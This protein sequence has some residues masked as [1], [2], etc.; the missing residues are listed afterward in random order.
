MDHL[1]QF[2]TEN[3]EAFDEESLPDGH[4]M[5]FVQKINTN[6][7]SKKRRLGMYTLLIAASVLLLMLIRF[8]FTVIPEEGSP[9]VSSSQVCAMRHEIDG[10]QLYYTMQVNDV[11]LQM[12]AF[13]KC[14]LPGARDL[15]N[16][17]DL[18]LYDNAQFEK[19]VLPALPCSNTAIYAM[20]QHYNASL[21]A[22]QL[23]L[24]Q[25][26]QMK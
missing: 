22:L 10:L 23:M 21:E 7:S 17:M 4:E 26:E 19:Q 12:A 24:A 1:K 25:L 8:S 16:E 15:L 20:S 13:A 3:R 2:I 14:D 18:V 6:R 11:V 5:R 9:A